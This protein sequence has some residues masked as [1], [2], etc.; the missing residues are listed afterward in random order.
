MVGWGWV[1]VTKGSSWPPMKK[2]KKIK[3]YNFDIFGSESKL[4]GHGWLK[5]GW[6]WTKGDPT[7]LT[8]DEKKKKNQILQFWYFQSQSQTWGAMVGW[9]RFGGDPR[10]QLTPRCKNKKNQIFESWYYQS[11]TQSG[12]HG[13]LR[14][15]LGW[16]NR[17]VNLGSG[18]GQIDRNC[19]SS[20]INYT[21]GQYLTHK[22]LPKSDRS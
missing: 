17:R 2:R 14:M 9:G 10:G 13:L 20:R 22:S 3:I 21:Y 12:G 11:Q 15:G 4:G 16:P 19:F 7:K 18:V 8:P 5:M 6:G 1:W